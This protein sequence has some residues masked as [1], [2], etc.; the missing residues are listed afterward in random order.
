MGRLLNLAE[1]S[2]FQIMMVIPVPRP[3]DDPVLIA[4]VIF[5]L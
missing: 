5:D 3:P 2:K 4:S 1:N